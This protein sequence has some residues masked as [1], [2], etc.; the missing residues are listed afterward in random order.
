MNPLLVFFNFCAANSISE[1]TIGY[2]LFGSIVTS[3]FRKDISMAVRRL[4][5]GGQSLKDLRSHRYIRGT[6]GSG[7]STLLYNL[8]LKE[9]LKYGAAIISTHGLKDLLPYIQQPER[10]HLI[11]PATERPCGINLL[12][13]YTNDETERLLI[14]DQ[15]VGLL[16]KLDEQ[17]WGANIE[18]LVYNATLAILEA[19]DTCQDYQGATLYN[20]YEFLQNER[21]REEVLFHIKTSTVIDAFVNFRPTSMESAVRRMRR[22]IGN[23]LLIA[24]LAHPEPINLQELIKNEE[25]LVADLGN[26]LGPLTASLIAEVLMSKLFLI[27]TTRSNKDRHFFCYFDEFQ[28]Y[29]NRYVNKFVEEGRKRNMPIVL[30]HQRAGQLTKDQQE[31]VALCG[32]WYIFRV[33]PDDARQLAR[34]YPEK[35]YKWQRFTQLPLYRVIYKEQLGRSIAYGVRNTKTLPFKAKKE[36]EIWAA[37]SQGPTREEIVKLVAERAKVKREVRVWQKEGSLSQL[38]I[39]PSFD[40]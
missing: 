16:S 36:Q 37:N 6:I 30:A 19:Q 28:T 17:A 40:F 5:W 18:E 34:A 38:E 13:R 2:L 32:S 14:A 1:F 33:T 3:A 22:L 20:V 25:I 10:V 39:K 7:K 26:E 21:Y 15:V 23:P 24:A 35:Q 4:S 12:E 9:C 27:S 11:S 29:S 8:F 31:A